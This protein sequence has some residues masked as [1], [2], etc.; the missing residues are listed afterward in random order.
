MRIHYLQHV[1]FEDLAW[2]ADWLKMRQFPTTKTILYQH[3]ILPPTEQFDWLFILG[4]PMNIYEEQLYPWLSREKKFIEQAITA[5]KIVIGICL[6]AQLLADVL[7]AKVLKNSH[8]EIGWFPV[9]LTPTAMQSNLFHTFP[10]TFMAFHWHG[11]TFDLPD[12][13]NR[14]AES[15]A[16]KNQAFQYQQNVFGFQFHTECTLRSI[17]NLITHCGDEI[18]ERGDFVQTEAQIKTQFNYIPTTN[19]LLQS[20]LE[21]LL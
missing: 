7:G 12:G 19:H 20:F 14:L 16:C 11:D 8:R 1:P 2:I 6:G 5:G 17:E 15:I 4:G 18:T 10:S 21:Q 9:T 3:E 13:S